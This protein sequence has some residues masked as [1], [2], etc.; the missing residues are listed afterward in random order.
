MFVQEAEPTLH[1][2]TGQDYHSH[3]TG[4]YSHRQERDGAS[5]NFPGTALKGQPRCRETNEAM[6]A[7]K[8]TSVATE[9]VTISEF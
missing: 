4:T 1:Q 7:E 5:T 2:Y 9:V 6:Q 3:T 8:N